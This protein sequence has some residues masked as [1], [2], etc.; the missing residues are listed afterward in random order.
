LQNKGIRKARAAHFGKAAGTALELFGV[1]NWC[2]GAELNCRHRD[3]QSRS[4]DGG[5][6]IVQ[7]YS[8]AEI[9]ELLRG[10][11]ILR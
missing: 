3:F 9:V 7:P 8:Q 10:E 4:R 5:D 6:I 2:R 11:R 1:K